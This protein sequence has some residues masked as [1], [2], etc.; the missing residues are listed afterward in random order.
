MSKRLTDQD[1]E[2]VATTSLFQGLSRDALD[3]VLQGATVLEVG[4][5]SLLFNQGDQADRFYILL[6]GNVKLYRT[7]AEGE[8]SVVEIFDG[9][10]SFAEAAMFSSARFPV[11]GETVRPSRLVLVPACEFLRALK[12]NPIISRTILAHMAR[13]YRNLMGDVIQL[14]TQSPAQRL[15]A[16]FLSL[17]DGREGQEIDLPYGKNLIAARVGMK[18]ESL[19]RALSRLREIGVDCQKNQLIVKSLYDLR[20]FCSS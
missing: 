20:R 2:Q 15:G 18:P 14:K 12:D 8:E 5:N 6:D 7:N 19:S 17:A 13:R 4:K 3:I 16:W 11:N 9:C 10:A 1:I